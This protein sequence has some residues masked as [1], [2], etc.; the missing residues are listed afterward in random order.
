VE[1]LLKHGLDVNARD[2][3]GCTPLMLAEKMGSVE[4]VKMLREW[5]GVGF[6]ARDGKGK[7]VLAAAA[8]SGWAEVVALLLGG[9]VVWML[10]QEIRAVA[11]H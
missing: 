4:V 7:E 11:R 3:E 9:G 10:I 8:R 5:D 1:V 6:H 2:D